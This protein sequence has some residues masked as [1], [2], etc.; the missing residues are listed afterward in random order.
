MGDLS[1]DTN[2]TATLIPNNYDNIASA[3]YNI[4]IIIEANNLEYT[5]PNNTPELLLN[6]T[7]PN[8]NKTNQYNRISSL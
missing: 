2:A 6:V 5:T 7:D 4:Y 8:G 1:D 3:M